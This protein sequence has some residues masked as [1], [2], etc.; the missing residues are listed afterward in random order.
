[1]RSR[2]ESHVL[3][4]V[5]VSRNRQMLSD[6]GQLGCN[7]LKADDLA[8]NVDLLVL[9]FAAGGLYGALRE[10]NGFLKALIQAGDKAAKSL[11]KVLQGHPSEVF[12]V[13]TSQPFDRSQ[14]ALYCPPVPDTRR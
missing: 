9:T 12:Y 3:L 8:G 2:S 11:I 4:A 14:E 6:L 10:R 13:P 7:G 5:S 1:M